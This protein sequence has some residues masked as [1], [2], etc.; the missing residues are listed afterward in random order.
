MC[1][2]DE[3]KASFRREVLRFGKRII[4]KRN[5]AVTEIDTIQPFPHF[6][7]LIFNYEKLQ[8]QKL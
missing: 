2:V 5:E 3:K 4:V 7:N 6:K 8:L 1:L